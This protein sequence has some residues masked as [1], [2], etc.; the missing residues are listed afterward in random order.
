[1]PIQPLSIFQIDEL[2]DQSYKRKDI[3]HEDRQAVRDKLRDTR[4]KLIAELETRPKLV[5]ADA[6]LKELRK[7]KKKFK[8]VEFGDDRI[9]VCGSTTWKDKGKI[10]AALKVL[11]QKD[12]RFLLI[13]TSK[14]AEQ[15]AITVGK[16]FQH[17]IV[18]VHP[19][20]QFGN[21]AVYI[22]NS[23]VFKFFKPTKVIAFHNDIEASI[24]TALFLKLGKK[25]GIPLVLITRDDDT[26]SITRKMKVVRE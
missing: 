7:T 8:K 16:S 22:R 6:I 5:G 12:T 2:I 19:I 13:G 26:K 18:Q 23:E 24:S 15:L 4:K 11:K 14:G 9:V 21:S 1:M 17:C 3:P 25:A 10:R 20:Q